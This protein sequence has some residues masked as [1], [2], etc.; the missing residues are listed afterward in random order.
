MARL[1]EK[2]I[3]LDGLTITEF[4]GKFT[5]D[6]VEHT[7]FTGI[8]GIDGTPNK[9]YL[10]KG[11]DGYIRIVSDTTGKFAK[12][13]FP[14]VTQVSVPAYTFEAGALN[15]TEDKASVK[16][17]LKKDNVIVGNEIE[18]DLTALINDK[19]VITNATIDQN[20]L[21]LKE[22]V[23]KG[24]LNADGVAI[25]ASEDG[26]YY[27]EHTINLATIAG[28]YK[29]ELIAVSGDIFNN[30]ADDN[31]GN[32]ATTGV[33]KLTVTADGSDSVLYI[34]KL[35]QTGKLKD[36]VDYT[37]VAKEIK[38]SVLSEDEKAALTKLVGTV[39]TDSK[40]YLEMVKIVDE[41]IAGIG[42]W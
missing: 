23:K 12:P 37:A 33:A 38:D 29:S 18:V 36:A 11:T 24:T 22:E 15:L 26:K 21:K 30:K 20:L 6:V 42:N 9:A 40:Y 32:A 17:A 1:I 7:A 25:Q 13:Y 14:T 2:I 4:L 16:L 39:A 27:R 19:G 35:G 31:G 28:K 10:I 3:K 34:S 41:R 8:D 5:A